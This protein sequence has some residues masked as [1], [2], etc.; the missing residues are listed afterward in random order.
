MKNLFL[1]MMCAALLT[2]CSTNIERLEKFVEKTEK[3]ADNFTADDWKKNGKEFSK[4]MEDLAEEEES[5]S[6]EDQLKRMK[7][8][9]KYAKISAKKI[10]K[11]LFED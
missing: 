4:L 7:L 2:S 8:A 3:N 9:T 1:A 5:L 11:K 10:G 6:S